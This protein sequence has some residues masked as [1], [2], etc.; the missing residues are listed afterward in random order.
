M[1]VRHDVRL[2][3]AATYADW[4]GA[5]QL[6][7][8]YRRWLHG[9]MGLDLTT[10]QR[11]AGDE[12]SDLP[13]FYR[14]PDGFLIV[15]WAGA[16]PV[17]MVGVH[18]YA[19]SIGELKRM[20]ASPTARG[21]GVGRALV[22]EAVSAAADLGFTEIWLQTEPD[23]MAAAHR[24]YREAGFADIPAYHDLGVAGVA[25]LGLQLVRSGGVAEDRRAPC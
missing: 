10:A 25:T 19:G 5:A 13:S 7:E 17:G 14:P 20:Y 4:A 11:G 18:R 2:T 15:A 22:T 24:L 9:A 16:R 12:F 23:T 21:M 3:R 6:L 1:D 8:E